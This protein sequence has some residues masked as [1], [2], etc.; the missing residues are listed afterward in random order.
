[1]SFKWGAIS[2]LYGR[3]LKL[4]DKFINLGTN[5]SSTENDV[6]IWGAYDKFP[7]FFCM[8]TFIGSTHMK[9]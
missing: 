1:M 6:N 3:S 4:V 7:D 5:I 9:L 8:G 2:T